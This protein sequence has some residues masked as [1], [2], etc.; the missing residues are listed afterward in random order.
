MFQL[1]FEEQMSK[2]LILILTIFLVLSGCVGTVEQATAPVSD[3]LEPVP[4][5]LAFT[6]VSRVEE[7]SDTRIEIFFPA[8]TG[9]SGKFVYDVYIGT[10]AVR[11]FSE[12]VIE[13]ELGQYRLTIDGL[14][15]LQKVSVRVE[16]RDKNIFA[17]SNSNKTIEL[18]TYSIEV[19]QFDGIAALSNLPGIA[20]KDQLR[21]RWVPAKF[22]STN[23]PANPRFYEISL[24][25]AGRV[26]PDGSS[27]ISLGRD[28]LW[29]TDYSAM[30]GRYVYQINSIDGV[31]EYVVKGLTPDYYYHV[32]IRCIHSATE[33]NEFFPELRGEV[34]TKAITLNT[35][36]DALTSLVFDESKIQARLLPGSLGFSA[37]DILWQ[38]A[39]GTFD[40]YRVYYKKKASS[41]TLSILANCST[42]YNPDAMSCKG[43]NF[44]KLKTTITGLVANET[45]SV[46]IVLCQTVACTDPSKRKVTNVIEFTTTPSIAQFPGLTGVELLYNLSEIGG[47]KLKFNKPD[48]STGYIDQ[49]IVSYKRTAD[50]GA[51]WIPLSDEPT[52]TLDP[53]DVLNANQLTVRGLELGT[54]EP[55]CFKVE[56]KVGNLAIQTNNAVHCVELSGNANNNSDF[57]GPTLFEF[58]GLQFVQPGTGNLTLYW[59]KPSAGYY[60]QYVVKV[61]DANVNPNLFGTSVD[62]MSIPLDPTFHEAV[63]SQ[64]VDQMKLTLPASIT[65]SYKIAMITNF[66]NPFVS[67]GDLPIVPNQCVWTC[68]PVTTTNG[69]Y[70]ACSAPSSCPQLDIN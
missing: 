63:L 4:E 42:S 49:Y 58:P 59:K 69:T 67:S 38:A 1:G 66:P 41:A 52:L 18:T 53:Y 34:N 25:K 37:S 24:V 65:K 56:A 68:N 48:L 13:K 29:N 6:G 30:N 20:G 12:D 40:H 44:D 27:Q 7:I 5:K 70:H 10:D 62:V 11:S 39:E 54:I 51:L 2:Q 9:G 43:E 50:N 26:N 36:N 55:Y 60:G 21:V 3:T 15:V 45:Y 33:D 46:Q 17:L 47:I 16:A 61:A 8:A 64:T 14:K 32:G 31:N 35:L 22:I 19:C 28:Q 23:N 57:R